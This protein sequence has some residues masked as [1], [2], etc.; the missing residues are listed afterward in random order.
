MEQEFKITPVL[1]A[2]L[3]FLVGCAGPTGTTIQGTVTKPVASLGVTIP[4]LSLPVTGTQTE[5]VT[6]VFTDGTTG[7]VSGAVWASSNPSAATVADGTIQGTGA[8]HASV[9]ASYGGQSASVSVT[10]TPQ[11]ASPA[12]DPTG[13]PWASQPG[14]ALTWHDE[15][16]GTA[17][18]TGKWTYDLGGGG[19][20]NGELETYTQANAAVGPAGGESCLVITADSGLNSA[21]LKSQGIFA[22]LYG[23]IEARIKLPAGKGIWPAFWMLGSN[24]GQVGWPACGETDIMEMVG[25]DPGSTAN[26]KVYGTI[27]WK[28]TLSNQEA[29][30]QPEVY[31]LGS[32]QFADGFHTFG[33]EWNPATITYFLDGIQTGSAPDNLVT[34]GTIF[35]QPFFLIFNL[36][37]GGQWPGSPDNQTTFPQTMA[38]DWVRIYQQ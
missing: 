25:G 37:V 32:G 3:V 14:W 19:W 10:V 26:A 7:R 35:Q 24:L 36:A 18:D 13:D 23:R 8:G 12:L 33:I 4:N 22:A 5:V 34:Q 28:G 31:T 38:V 27:H 15:F 2:F 29:S 30:S 21:R 1:T 17:V 6:A 16:N 11:G 20:G 9:T